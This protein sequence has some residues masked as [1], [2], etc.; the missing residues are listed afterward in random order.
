MTNE[1]KHLNIPLQNITQATPLY[2]G[3]GSKLKVGGGTHILI[4]GK[5]CMT[6]PLK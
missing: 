6:G 4:E 2:R 1:L 3:V 5:K